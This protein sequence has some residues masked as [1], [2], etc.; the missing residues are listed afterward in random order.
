MGESTK[1]FTYDDKG[2]VIGAD[3]TGSWKT[4]VNGAKPGFIMPANPAVG[5]SY[6]QEYSPPAQAVD[7]AKILS[8][9]QKVTVPVGT[10][11]NVIETLETSASEPGARETK[12][13]AK[14]VG[15]VLD[16]DLL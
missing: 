6:Y 4:G 11:S 8:L 13:Y 15:L 9:S 1:A 5:F 12:Y 3:T 14:G 16:N 2:N 7:Q 10:F